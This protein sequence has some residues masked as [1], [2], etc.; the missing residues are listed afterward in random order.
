MVCLEVTDLAPLF[1]QRVYSATQVARGK[2]APDLFLF[3]AQSVGENPSAC[4]VIEDSAAGIQA[5]RAAGMAVIGF[6]GASHATDDLAKCLAAAGASTVI[7]S[8]AD[9]PAAVEELVRRGTS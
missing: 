2:P 4:I 3:A 1:G 7:S 5:G 8:M 6:A 9:L